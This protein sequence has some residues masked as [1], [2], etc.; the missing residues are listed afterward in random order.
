[1][2]SGLLVLTAIL[3]FGQGVA[4]AA[5]CAMQ[6]AF[7]Q[8]DDDGKTTTAVWADKTGKGLLFGDALHVNTDGTRRSYRVMDFWGAADAVNNLC[9]AMSDKCAGMDD[10]H[11]KARRI[12]TEQARAH[13]WP[14][15]ELKATRIDPQIIPLKDGK[16]CPELA[17]GF[18]VSAT[19]LQ[20]STGAACDVATYVDAMVVPAIV[21]PGRAK[22]DAPTEFET[23]NAKVGDLAVVMSGDGSVLTYAVV[24]DTGPSREI[25]E[26]TIALAG[27][28]LGKSAEPANYREVRG[29]TPYVGKGWDV[30][31]AFVLVLPGSRNGANPYMTV[32][33]IEAS[34][35]TAFATWGGLE[36]LKA[37]AAIY[38]RN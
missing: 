25:G 21:I 5:D 30:P 7:K 1:V 9:N 29:K 38:K 36:R 17:G 37:C 23:R 33:R 14:A 26:G 31:K 4:R 32:D 28:L 13:F 6:P 22:H 24:G 10:A 34:A 27:R 15:D 12:A 16:P 19:A 35:T 18:L 8:A 20:K 3:S 2:R 11:L